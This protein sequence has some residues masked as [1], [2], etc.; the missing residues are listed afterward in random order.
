MPSVADLIRALPETE[1]PSSQAVSP[2]LADLALRPVP[3]GRLRRIGLLGTLQAKIAVAYFFYWVRGW[4]KNADQ[5]EQ[6]LAETHWRTAA[7]VLDSMSYLRGATMKVGQMLGNFPDIVPAAFVETLDQLHFQAPPMHWSL[8]REMVFNELGDDPENIFASFETRAFAAASIGQVHGARLKGGQ[9]VAIKIQYPGIAR[10]IRED[11]RNLL[12][13]M[14][15][16]RLSADWENTREQF[17]DLRIRL[18]RETEYEREAAT[19]QRV[20][21]LFGEDEG[22]VIPRVF[23]EHSTARVLT[24]ERIEGMHLDQFLQTD[25]PQELRNEFARKMLRAWYRML[26]TGRMLYADFHPGNFIFMDDGRLGVIDFGCMV[27]LDDT[28]WELFRKMDRPLTTGRREDRIEALKEWSWISNDPADEERVRLTEQFADWSWHSRYSGE[29]DFSDTDDFRR[30]IDVFVEMVRKRYSRARPCTPMMARQQ[31]GWR[32]MLYRLAA[33][34]DVAP[35]A[36]EEVR[37]TGWDRSD[38][39]PR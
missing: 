11:F 22:I 30:G 29:F 10:T 23:P 39:A 31:L 2:A 34:I 7:R 28:L 27:E 12:L 19:L 18:E 33:K 15:P 8:L 25:P 36:E 26:F 17:D 14:L 4:F 38:Y 20:R 24:M 35:I 21:S 1:L 13:F 16:A 37:A 3:V 5:R 9:K 32:A 6:L